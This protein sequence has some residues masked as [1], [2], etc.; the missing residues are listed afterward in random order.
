M[1]NIF[2]FSFEDTSNDIPIGI[3]FEIV[4][5]KHSIFEERDTPLELFT[6]YDYLIASLSI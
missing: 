6:T 4:L 5:F 2:D 1:L 3:S